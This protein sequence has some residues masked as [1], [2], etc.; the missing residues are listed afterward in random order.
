ALAL[1]LRAGRDVDRRAKVVQLVVQG[2]GQTG[3]GVDADLQQASRV[4]PLRDRQ[5]AQGALHLNRRPGRLLRRGKDRHDGVAN[6]LDDS[7]VV[8]PD[9]S[10]EDPE[11]V[12]DQAEGPRL[13][14]PLVH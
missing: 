14:D 8:L 3:P 13:S 2:Y 9:R 7:A 11:V 4:Y 12:L 5:I 1:M 6:G 10:V